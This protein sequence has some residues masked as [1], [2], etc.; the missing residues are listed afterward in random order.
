MA[1]EQTKHLID[2]SRRA[3]GSLPAAATPGGVIDDANLYILMNGFA[4]AHYAIWETLHNV[5]AN[6]DPVLNDALKTWRNAG[7]KAQYDDRAGEVRRLMSHQGKHY[8]T[9]RTLEWQEDF[10]NDTEHPVHS[11]VFAQRTGHHGTRDLTF[12]EWAHELFWWWWQQIH[13][14]ER[15]YNIAK[16][17][18]ERLDNSPF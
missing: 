10:M 6:A 8:T 15:L 2:L 18:K 7:A 13:E 9:V 17:S 4:G 12:G 11:H 14:I 5:E 1:L 16:R 3:A